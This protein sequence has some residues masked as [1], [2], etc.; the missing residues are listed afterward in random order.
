MYV[1]LS[2]GLFYIVLVYLYD[3]IREVTPQVPPYNWCSYSPMCDY[4]IGKVNGLAPLG[5]FVVYLLFFV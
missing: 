2:R 3:Y 4:I 5:S 1:T